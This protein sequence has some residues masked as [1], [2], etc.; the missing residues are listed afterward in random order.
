MPV[1][2]DR[3]VVVGRE[4]FDDAGVFVVRD[5]LALIQTVDFFAPIVDDPYVFGQIAAATWPNV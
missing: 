5:D 2:A 4:T 3:R 1:H